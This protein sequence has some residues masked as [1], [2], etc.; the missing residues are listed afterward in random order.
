MTRDSTYLLESRIGWS[1][2]SEGPGAAEGVDESCSLDGSQE[3]GEP[4]VR[5]HQLRYGGR[6]GLGH[7]WNNAVVLDW[8]VVVN[9]VVNWLVMDCMVNGLMVMDCMVNWLMVTNTVRDYRM[10]NSGV[11][12]MVSNWSVGPGSDHVNKNNGNKILHVVCVVV[13]VLGCVTVCCGYIPT[14]VVVL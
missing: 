8:L 2:D 11:N 14:A 13:V 12:T 10:V 3:G 6:G 1:E 7:H 5:H 4:A 9:C